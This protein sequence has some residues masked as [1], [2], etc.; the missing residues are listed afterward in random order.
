MARA[1]DGAGEPVLGKPVR[2]SPAGLSEPTVPPKPDRLRPADRPA[3]PARLQIG[4]LPRV[5]SAAIQFLGDT[6]NTCH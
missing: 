1:T 4:Q 2:G 3:R 6:Y 5:W